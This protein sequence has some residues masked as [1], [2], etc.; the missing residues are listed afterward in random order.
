MILFV[1]LNTA[2][3]LL[4]GMAWWFQRRDLSTA[5]NWRRWFF[6]I[7]LVVNSLSTL[8]LILLGLFPDLLDP[9]GYHTRPSDMA[10]HALLCF[11]GAGIVSAAFG[12]CGRRTSRILLISNGLLTMLMWFAIAAVSVD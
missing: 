12:L 5:S 1:A 3:I 4:L 8:S 6:L 11:V 9:H 10:S 7:G 2:A